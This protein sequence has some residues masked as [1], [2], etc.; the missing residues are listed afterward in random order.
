MHSYQEVETALGKFR[1]ACGPKGVTMVHPADTA[2]AEFEAAYE[3]CMGVKPKRGKI[4]ASYVRALRDAAAGRPFEAVP[5]DLG[6]LPGF[7][8]K[9]LSVLRD[10]PRGEVRTYGW[11]ARRAGHP[12]A[13]RAAGGAMARNP[14]PILIPCHRVVPA[15]GGI[16]NFG[17]GAAMKRALLRSEGAPVEDL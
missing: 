17:L 4:P 1:L 14:V 12:G 7:Q 16:G 3:R 13:A 6:G 11:L 8:R 10:V 5:I 9:V 2:P 15:S